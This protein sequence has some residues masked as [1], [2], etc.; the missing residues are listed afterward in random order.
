VSA[1]AVN[2]ATL[3][4]APLV[5]EAVA[6]QFGLSLLD[7]RGPRISQSLTRAR[8]VAAVLLQD[9]TLLS[10]VEIGAALGRRSNTAGRSLLLAGLKS[11]GDDQRFAQA[12]EQ[13]RQRL[14]EGFHG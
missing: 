6:E 10:Q 11:R 3:I 4:P 9:F 12:I 2:A 8:Q 5:I 14:L 1:P 13:A 7:L